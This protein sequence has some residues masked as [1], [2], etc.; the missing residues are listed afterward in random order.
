MRFPDDV[1]VLTDG[2]VTLRA[3]RTSDVA[4][5]HEQCLDPVSVQ[6]TTV[7]VPYSVA[8]AEHYVGGIVPA[9]WLEDSEWAFAVEAADESGERRFAGT[10]SLRNEGSGRAEIAYGSHPWVRGRGLMLRALHLLLDWGFEERGL[11]TVIWWA[12]QGNWASRKVAWRL[13]FSM[14]GALQQWLPQRGELLDAWVGVLLAGEPRAPRHP[15]LE[16]PR[17]HG[18]RVLLRAH[19]PRDVVRTQEAGDDPDSQQQLQH[20]ACPFTR[21]SAQAYLDS[22]A[23]LAATG[24]AISWTA[25]DPVTDEALS[26]LTLF[27]IRPGH[28]AEV[29]YFTHPDARGKGVTTEAVEL[30]CRHAFISEEDGG[31]GL[32]AVRLI[33]T[34][35]NA[36]SRAVAE[37]AGFTLV[38]RQRLGTRMRDGT[39]RDSV[40][41]DLLAEEHAGRAR[42]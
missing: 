37:A 11:R 34:E 40:H 39:S 19:E 21:E 12:N 32:Q 41:Y 20:F 8:D 24:Q 2:V 33:T 23:N 7:P 42:Q 13:G 30:I 16:T 29:G 38:G 15:W 18:P 10:V 31:L 25:A 28:E 22:R 3:H 27:R 17:I 6:W 14:D 36:G 4:G 35:T 26:F 1:P 5:I 9:G